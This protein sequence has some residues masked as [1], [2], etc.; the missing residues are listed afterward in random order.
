MVSIRLKKD[1]QS[2]LETLEEMKKQ[3]INPYPHTFK[4]SLHIKEIVN[5]PE[6]FMNKKVRIAGRVMRI[7]KHG[8]IFFADLLQERSKIQLIFRVNELGENYKKAVKWIEKG[9]WIGVSGKVI[10]SLKGELSVLV[11]EWKMLS[12]SLISLPEKWYGLK[13]V[14]ERYRKRYLDLI[15]N[16]KAR[17]NF[18]MRFK[19][20]DE[21]RNF[22][23][24]KGFIEVETPIL[25]PIYGGAYA[26]P[27]ITHVNY[28]DENWFLR[29]SPEL[30]LKR[31]IIS[32]FEKV[33]EIAKVFRN[34]SVD[35]RH[36]PEFTILEAYQAYADYN[37]MMKLTEEMFAHLCKILKVEKVK[38]IIDGQEYEIKL[39]PP[40]KKITVHEAIEKYA[41]IDPERVSDEKIKKILKEFGIEIKP[42]NR[43]LALTEI[44]DEIAS[45]NF[46][47]PTFA[48]DY[49]LESTPLCKWH[50]TKE[51][52]V[53]RFELFIGGMEIANAYTEL[54]DPIVQ[55]KLFIEQVKMRELG[56]EEAHEYDQDFIEAL[57][58]GMPPTGGIGY[59]IDR[60]VMLFTE[61]YSIKEVIL[62]PMMK[63]EKEKRDSVKILTEL[64]F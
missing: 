49:P 62:W 53:E 12:K 35:V 3:G 23:K 25:Q 6:S 16:E 59:G 19:I 36:N 33:F 34:E 22:L 54:N 24:S 1:I 41:G 21:I 8:K 4:P 26:K 29:I 32:G 60:I 15:L 43:G 20:I 27:F 14:E 61:S 55:N 28:L 57:M 37:D 56:F 30:Y 17:K 45:K 64:T 40:F 2:R 58:Y 47:Q 44:F 31:L 63:K 5:N 18:E 7:R 51:G 38:R 11:E 42:Y 13:D 48:I 9:D 10:R 52:L 50:R 39:T 46:I